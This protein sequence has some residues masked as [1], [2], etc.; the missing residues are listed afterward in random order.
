MISVYDVGNEDFEKNGDA[1][2]T[3]RSGSHT[4]VAGGGYD[5][6]LVHPIDPYGKWRHLVPGAIV[7]APVPVETIENS[8]SGLEADIY[9]TTGKT[10]L[11]D[12]PS[13]PSRIVYSEWNM[14]TDYS[15]GS[16]VTYSRYPSHTNYQCTYFD[17]DSMTKLVSPPLS[18]WWTPI[19]DMSSGANV[20]A[21]LPAGTEL[22]LVEDYN[23]S[24]F[25]ME[26]K[27][28]IEGYVQKS[29]VVFDRH[30]TPE[31]NQ[32]R[33]ITEQ[34]FRVEE[35]VVD[36][37]A[38]TVSVKG[39]HVSYD[40]SGNLIQDV[41]VSQASPAMAIMRITD[42]LMIPYRGMIAT[43]LT[44]EDNGTY[45][46][47]IKGK[48]GIFALLDPDKGIVPGFN[49]KF[50]RDNWDV[51]I[52]QRTGTDRGYRI[53]YGVNA[54][55]IQWKQSSTQLV[56]RIVP[57]AKNSGG[58]DLYLPE[59]WIDSPNI[60]DYPVIKMD[61]LTVQGQVGKERGDGNGNWTEEDLLDE[62][63]LKASEKFTV[64]HVDEIV[65][66]VTIQIEQLEN[67]AEYSWLKGLKDLLLYDVV[68]AVDERIGLDKELYVSQ[69]EYDIIKKK[70]V[71]IKLSNIQNMNVRT[72]AGYNMMNN[73]ISP[74]KLTDEVTQVIV[75][76]AIDILG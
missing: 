70:I 20:L 45:T 42:G 76:K 21:T 56:N 23:Q 11:R 19:P 37:D 6:Q 66:E 73:S 2:L 9:I 60:N 51:F 53:R 30:V 72:V 54:R 46:G 3:P 4:Q 27:Y 18:S 41:S 32:P 35:P 7:K 75:E 33:V 24:W 59:M 44:T 43:N 8:Y 47:E 13:A 48:N 36:N 15:V 29:N 71:G 40:L 68:H 25:K 1:V 52:M 5:I 62:M 65:E 16:R 39:K 49:A 55:G 10:D 69:I 61:R 57:V 22:Y 67:T 28:G 26:T 63:R 12:G 50:T 58:T 34:L 64:S 38:K 74:E 14:N 17:P 31:E